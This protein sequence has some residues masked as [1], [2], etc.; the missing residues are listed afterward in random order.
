MTIQLK[1]APGGAELIDALASAAMDLSL[2]CANTPSERAHEHLG[3]Y[4]ASIRAALVEAI[5]VERAQV[6]LDA[7]RGAV[8]R[9]KHAIEST[10]LCAATRSSATRSSA[11]R[12]H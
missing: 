5:G 6:V 8:M 10:W 1:D 4:C 9:R 11:T 2:L 7:F 3:G 12:R